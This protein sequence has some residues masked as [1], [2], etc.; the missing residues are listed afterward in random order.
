MTAKE[1][2]LKLNGREYGNEIT[3]AE[4]ASAKEAGLVVVFGASD[5]LI[6]FRGAIDDEVD[7]YEGGIAHIGNQ[8]VFRSPDNCDECGLCEYVKNEKDGC[9]TISARWYKGDYA[10]SYRTEIPH[11]TF[12]ILEDG[13][14]YCRGIVFSIE[15]LEP[16][17]KYLPEEME[18]YFNL[19][20]GVSVSSYLPTPVKQQLTEF[21]SYLESEVTANE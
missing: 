19:L 3:S 12:E 11:E 18:R 17:S 10:W 2:A 6:E 16:A 21:I 13:E 4:E 5:D 20:R 14:R 1:L 9:V 7:C 15:D 8:G